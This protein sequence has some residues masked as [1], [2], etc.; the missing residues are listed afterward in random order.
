MTEYI[1]GLMINDLVQPSGHQA[2]SLKGMF[3][4]QRVQ[5]ALLNNVFGLVM[6]VQYMKGRAIKLLQSSLESMPVVH[7][8]LKRLSKFEI[9][10]RFSSKI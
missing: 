3:V 5:Q 7:Q 4:L 8:M 10:S 9:H 6:I 1:E 2:L